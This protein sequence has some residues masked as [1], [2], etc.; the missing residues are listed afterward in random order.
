MTLAAGTKLGPYEI[1]APIGAG[2]MGE[3]YK[4]RDERLKR[5][6]AIKVLPAT[7]SQD[8]DRLRRFEQEAQAAGALNHPN[9]TAVHDFGTVDGAPYIVTELLEGETL[10]AR[11]AGGAIPV[12]KATDYAIQLAR[13]LAAAHEKGIVHRDL[14]PENLFLTSDGRVKILDFGLAKLTQN[15]SPAGA[16]TNLP[17]VSPST[18]PGVVMGTLGYMSPEQVK[19]KPADARSDIFAF[20]AIL[21]EM[22]SGQRAFHRDS[23]A[24]TMSAILREEPPDLSASNK[25]VQPGLERIVRHSLEKNPEERF[26]SAHDLAFDLEAL[27][28]LSGSAPANVAAAKAARLPRTPLATAA[29]AVLVALAAG[30]FLGKSKGV[31]PPPAFKQLTFR[32]GAIWSARF[33]SDGK[34]VLTTGAW[35]GKPAEIYVTRPESPEATPFGVP[36]ADV[37]AV[38]STGEVAVLLRADFD[39]AF[40]RAGTLARVGAAGG[41]PR[42]MLEH[43]DFADWTPDGKDIAVVRLV[44]NKARLEYPIGKVVY[45]TGGWIGH[46]RFSPKGDRIA[47]LDHPQF[48]DDGGTVALL[49][50]SSGKKTTLSPRYATEIGLAWSP[51]GSEIWYTAAEVGSN[52]ALHAVT[53]SGRHRILQRGGGVLT[54]HDIARDGRVLL[55]HDELETG[56]LGRAAGADRERDLKW[57]DWSLALDLARDG[58]TVLFSET[59]EGGG[60]GYSVYIRGLDGSPAVRLGEGNALT[61]SP[62]GKKA[63]ALV[64]PPGS[65]DLVVY[66]T[67]A[68]ETVKID[69]GGLR[70]RTASWLP[71]SRHALISA[72][73]G[74]KPGR[75]YLLDT[76]GGPMKPITAEGYRGTRLGPDGKHFVAFGPDEAYYLCSVEG[77][78]PVRIPNSG[79]NDRNRSIAPTDFFWGWSPDGRLY[80]ARGSTTTIP[81]K[82]DLVDPATG[83]ST[84]FRDFAPAD[85]A[86][87]NSLFG[88]RI[89]PNGA[90]VYSY[91]R[92]LST[93]FLVEGIR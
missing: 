43:V 90:Y 75:T 68:G 71:D 80:V 30:Y 19:G 55:A 16:A 89:A 38:S 73:E 84:H 39:S 86:G 78:E 45:E 8:P 9:I 13:G 12:R 72:T 46:P 63:F 1:V 44:K 23:A 51:D 58:S 35:D 85:T 56:I 49:D 3:V 70:V 27:S 10:R 66:P 61:L 67:G 22:L 24:E 81:M 26:H 93:L 88:L 2:G 34:S 20:G 77:G 91:Y 33:G 48:N 65:A 50:L 57:L 69:R 29:A 31:S 40:S 41:A 17:T 47:F 87:I 11:L 15:E 5:D 52:R 21:Y 79:P 62:D 59:G 18:E 54:L 37:A 42:E 4:A 28:G 36:S 25:S 14:K 83:T 32:R 74:D 6:V 64:G 7:Y 82:V 76:S 60:K 53:P 92:D